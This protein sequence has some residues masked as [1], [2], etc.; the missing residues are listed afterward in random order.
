MCTYSRY[1][2]VLCFTTVDTQIS[3]ETR[4]FHIRARPSSGRWKDARY[5][6]P[7]DA[8]AL[9]TL[10]TYAPVCRWRERERESDGV[11]VGFE[12]LPLTGVTSFPTRRRS[13]FWR[14]RTLRNSSPALSRPVY[15]NNINNNNCVKRITHASDK[16]QR[17][18]A[19]E[20]RCICI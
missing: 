14:I 20:R 4:A 19:V 16:V 9:H 1:T 11:G 3:R 8:A 13:G 12:G 2:I 6:L 7:T 18:L 15:N 17:T 5:G 10:H